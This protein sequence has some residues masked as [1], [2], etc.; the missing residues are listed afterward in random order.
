MQAAARAHAN[1]ALVK[2]WGKRDEGLNLPAVGSLSITLDALFTETRVEFV[3][4]LTDDE[5]SIDGQRDPA[6]LARVSRFLDRVRE[7]AGVRHRA[8]VSSTNN[9][10]TGA[11]LASSASGFAALTL[12]AAK[13][14]ELRLSP[15]ELSA[16]A[17]LGSGSA[18][19]SLFGGFVEMRAGSRVD[20]TDAVALPL[21]ATEDWPLEVLVVLTSV[22]RKTVGSTEGMRRSA[23]SSPYYPAWLGGAAQ[24]LEQARAAV[25]ARDFAGLAKVAELSCLKMHSVMLTTEPTMLY[26]NGVTV[27]VMHAVQRAR[28]RGV[29]AFFT[30]DAGPQVKV[31]AMPGWGEAFVDE[32]SRLPGVVRVVRTGL[33]PAARLIGAAP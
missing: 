3:Q 5:L 25:R 4:D 29:P 31:V 16:L 2:Y 18:P 24:D 19:R 13:A 9:F 33:G 27:D 30:I 12:A 17:R 21:A 1:I 28:S 22:G 20:G 26:W 11:G 15:A 32:L 7:L 8:R 23:A 14:L 6:E 10:P